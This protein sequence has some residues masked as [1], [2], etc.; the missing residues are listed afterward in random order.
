MI[1]TASL[2]GTRSPRATPTLVHPS[3]KRS[4][5]HARHRV[6]LTPT[7]HIR[8][9][10][11][12]HLVGPPQ[13]QHEVSELQ[14]AA[15]PR[16]LQRPARR[17]QTRP[18]LQPTLAVRVLRQPVRAPPLRHPR[19][20]SRPFR[21]LDPSPHSGDPSGLT[22]PGPDLGLGSAALLPVRRHVGNP[23]TLSSN[24][25]APLGSMI[26]RHDI[27]CD[28]EQRPRP[29]ARPEVDSPARTSA[30]P[31]AR[32]DRSGSGGPCPRRHRRAVGRSN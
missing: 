15:H 25:T 17:K 18:L 14:V 21:H 26:L 9:V 24:P 12:H 31:I 3:R 22:G 13:I 20:Q 16:H 8:Q 19:T 10:I 28:P 4:N 11:P 6:R 27:S 1:G 2:D 7:Q 32:R 5:L 29:A 23:R 30:H